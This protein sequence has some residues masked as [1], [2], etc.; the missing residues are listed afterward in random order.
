MIMEDE[1]LLQLLALEHQFVVI[2]EQLFIFFK[3]LFLLCL[4]FSMC[5]LQENIL[6]LHLLP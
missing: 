1:L 4:P 2:S 3:V 5:L 6:L